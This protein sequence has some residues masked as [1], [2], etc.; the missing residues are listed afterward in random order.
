MP[1]RQK[2]GT[3]VAE[4]T[5][6]GIFAHPDDELMCGGT[7]AHYAAQDVRIV[8]A[9]AT[10]GEAGQ[11][12]EAHLATR[13]TIAEARSAE[14]IAAARALGV[15]DVRFLG[16]RDSG[17][18]GT[19]ENDDPASLHRTD[20]TEATGRAIA[21]IRDVKPDVVITHDPTGGYGHPD[22]IAVCRFVTA[23][24][25]LA[26]DP[27]AYPEEGQPWKPG[28]LFYGV[29]SRSFFRRMR[30]AMEAAGVDTTPFQRPEWENLGY[31][32]A[33]ITFS[34]DATS[35]RE[36]KWA[37]F[38]AH[39][40]QFGPESPLRQMPE[41]LRQTMFTHEHYILARPE[42]PSGVIGGLFE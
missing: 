17:M 8:I 16:F 6:L 31:E 25:D 41:D 3:N 4:R 18:A 29:M 2:K 27:D 11:I 21:L 7:I 26:G 10:R 24:F 34:F 35:Q 23:A 9:C 15:S 39:R 12:S 37:G 33:E 13:E 1:S 20:P 5:L 19:P 32:D 28:R 40:T 42:G 38:E 14:L 30:E 36:A 22:H